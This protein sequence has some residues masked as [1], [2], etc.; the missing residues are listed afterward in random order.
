MAARKPERKAA[1]VAEAKTA[2]QRRDWTARART[3]TFD[4]IRYSQ[5]VALM[6]RALPVAAAAILA[7][8]IIYSLLPRPSDR[9]QI[10]AQHRG[11]IENDLSMIKP[12]L[13]GTDD[14]GNPYVIT[15][16]KAV[17]DPKDLHRARLTKID[18]DMTTADG[19]WM[20]VN[21]DH[22]NFDMGRGLLSLAGGIAFF[23]DSGYELHTASLDVEMRK[24]L[25]RGRQA[26]NG[27]GPF[28]TMRADRFEFDRPH[29]M[30]HLTGDVHT[31][32]FPSALRTH[33]K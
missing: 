20:S 31:T 22:G 12:R 26:V 23:S 33:R 1:A 25:Y 13:T 27:H 6:K 10:T 9:I 3:T 32:I 18:A 14:E 30:L 28:G 2:R 29:Q 16:E 15:A 5:F 7:V 8:V 24:G 17:Q 4:A 21:A 19:H 11:S